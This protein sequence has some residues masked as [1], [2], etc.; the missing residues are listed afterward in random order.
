MEEKKKSNKVVIIGVVVAV[1][2]IGIICAVVF[3]PKKEAD[4]AA[5]TPLFYNGGVS[6]VNTAV[7]TEYDDTSVVEYELKDIDAVIENP[8]VEILQDTFLYDAP[9]TTSNQIQ[10]LKKGDMYPCVADV[11]S[12]DVYVGWIYTEFDGKSGF[13][14]MKDA[15]YYVLDSFDEENIEIPESALSGDFSVSDIIKDADS[16]DVNANGASLINEEEYEALIKWQ[17][18]QLALE[19]A[20]KAE[21]EQSNSEESDISESEN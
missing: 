4:D 1:V 12:E 10:L 16:D 20:N 2:V 18:E 3:L 8:T 6:D 19:E 9:N 7:S 15:S 13:I 11:Y 5:D 21:Q 17:E 14:N